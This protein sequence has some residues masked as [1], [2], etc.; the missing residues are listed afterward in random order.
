MDEQKRPTRAI[1]SPLPAAAGV[2][3]FEERRNG[4]TVMMHARAGGRPGMLPGAPWSRLDAGMRETVPEQAPGLTCPGDA[5][6][7]PTPAGH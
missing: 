4:A 6:I 5:G 3:T 2:D 7:P 1:E